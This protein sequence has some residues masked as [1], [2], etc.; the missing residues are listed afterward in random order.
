PLLDTRSSIVDGSKPGTCS[1]TRS[2]IVCAKP[3]TRRPMIFSGKS[4]GN[5]SRRSSRSKASVRLR[6]SV[7]AVLLPVRGLRPLVGGVQ[8]G[9]Y[10][11]R[12][13]A[14]DRA[15]VELRDRQQLLR[16]RAHHQFVGRMHFLA[17]DAPDLEWN[18]R[19][20]RELGE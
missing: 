19:L 14:A 12:P 1:M 9:V 5:S 4:T 11:P 6:S 13:A 18:A 17:Q 10:R 15:P 7:M 20:G 2:D 3:S 16:G 8:G